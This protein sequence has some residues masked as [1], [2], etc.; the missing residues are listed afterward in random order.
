MVRAGL[1]VV[2]TMPAGLVARAQESP[3]DTS[4]TRPSPG[5]QGYGMHGDRC[6]GIYIQPV[7]GT[8]LWLASLTESFEP[9][10]LTS[11]AD[12]V[13]E[14]TPP[15]DRRIRLRAQG[16]KRDL[17]YRM[18]AIRPAESRSYRWPSDLL[19][20]ERVTADRIG[21]LG[22]ARYPIGGVEQDVY[23]PLRITQHSPAP[24]FDTVDLV[25]FPT[26][27]LTEVYL[28][29][30]ALEDDGRPRRSIVQGDSLGYG[31]YP[32]GRAV[33]VKLRQL[34]DPGLYY[35]ELAAALAP[36]GFYTV[37]YWIFR[38]H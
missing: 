18:D 28:T 9:Y 16:I 6:E 12:L 22:W 5:P 14:W 10:D 21:V 15:G 34:R 30:A 20:A 29:I 19:S 24:P 35:V 31:F 33:H 11:R 1:V 26:V 13:V 7:A 8:A 38:G 17:Y 25:L 27:E 32:A 23:V 3:C 36:G 37:R 2:L 4:L